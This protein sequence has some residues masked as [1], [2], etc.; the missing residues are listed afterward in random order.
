MNTGFLVLT[1]TIIPMS[2]A[3]DSRKRMIACTEDSARPDLLEKN[4]FVGDF[5]IRQV[6]RQYDLRY[7]E[8]FCFFF[9]QPF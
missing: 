1:S 7:I 4:S 8:A 9:I 6:I 5:V 2:K 3:L